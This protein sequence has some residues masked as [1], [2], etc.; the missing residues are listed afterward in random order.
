[1]P[2]NKSKLYLK[3]PLSEKSKYKLKYLYYDYIAW[4][5]HRLKNKFL[6]GQFDFPGLVEIE[7]NTYCNLR[8]EFCPNSKYT[9]GLAKNKK[10]MSPELFKKII[11]DLASFKFRGEL[12]FDFYGEPLADKRLPEFVAYANKKLP[13]AKM[14]I[15]TNGYFLTPEL[16]KQLIANGIKEFT[17]SQ[18]SE[19]IPKNMKK[20]FEYLK[21]NPK[22]PNVIKWRKFGHDS[23]LYNRGGD[24]D[25]KKIPDKPICYYPGMHYNILWNG[26]VIICCNDYHGKINFGNLS[27]QSILEIWNS[28]KYKAI[29]K[30]LYTQKYQLPICKTCVGITN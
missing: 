9:R 5:L 30:Q 11:N 28:P 19:E 18:Y 24:V 25:T 22:V 26:D 1:M 15:N 10:I 2:I 12:G 17:F 29:R 27:K 14:F 3:L 23:V 8:C 4:P 16:Y 13:K 6:Y 21:A 20:T 7:T